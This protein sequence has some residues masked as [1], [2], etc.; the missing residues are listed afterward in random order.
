MPCT[1]R[2]EG[3]LVSIFMKTDATASVAPK[4][5]TLIAGAVG[6][7]ALAASL[8]TA[9]PA[10]AADELT[11]SVTVNGA[12]V[13][14]ATVYLYRNVGTDWSMYTTTSTDGSGAFSFDMPTLN[15]SYATYYNTGGSSAIYSSNSSWDGAAST[16]KMNTEFTVDNGSSTKTSF[17]KALPVNT[18]AINANFIDA[19]TGAP[20]TDQDVYQEFGL[21]SG[22]TDA[23]AI[24]DSATD[25]DSNYYASSYN[26]PAVLL[27]G[28]AAGTWYNS[29]AD[30]DSYAAGGTLTE[31]HSYAISPIPVAV[32]ATT[33]VTVPVYNNALTDAATLIDTTAI[34][35]GGVA[36][37]GGLLTVALPAAASVSYSVQWYNATGPIVGAT[38]PSYSPIASDLGQKLYAYVVVTSP[39]HIPSVVGS[40]YGSAKVALGDPN[41][42]S[43]AVTG[44]AAFGSTVKAVVSATLAGSNTYQWYLNGAP[45]AGADGSS[46]AVPAAAVAGALS[47]AVKSAVQGH[48][49]ATIPSPAVVVAKDAATVKATVAKKATTK[50]KLKVKVA[51]TAGK[52]GIS[53]TAKVKV[54]YTKTKFKTV[55]VKSNKSATVTLPALKKGTTTIKVVY[56]GTSQYAAKTV[57]YKV[58]VTTA[59]KK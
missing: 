53:A 1:F 17:S 8:L 3:I 21:N 29:R 4:R 14:D 37:V 7:G 19:A 24:G 45:I 32:G 52:S 43:V 26:N 2:R 47:V 15:G 41:A 6:V 28:V 22:Y 34:T 59:K 30:V 11:G 27:G 20:V 5:R 16:R 55:T 9:T 58:K 25:L 56:P 50:T 40:Y 12:A 42:G 51:L 36:K 57:S 33:N 13:S 54:F 39:N 49:D 10:M 48:T 31:Y 44:A 18:G 35:I 38:T 46:Y 23:G